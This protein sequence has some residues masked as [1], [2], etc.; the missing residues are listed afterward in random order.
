MSVR[1]GE[2]TEEV[3]IWIGEGS[4]AKLNDRGGTGRG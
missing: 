2:G 3:K 1:T 4:S